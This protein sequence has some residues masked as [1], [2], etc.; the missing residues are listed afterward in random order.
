[1]IQGL[2]IR[3]RFQ[4]SWLRFMDVWSRPPVLSETCVKLQRDDPQCNWQIRNYKVMGASKEYGK[5]M[6]SAYIRITQIGC[7]YIPY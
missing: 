4:A 2:A 6:Y 5:V 7:S 1:M 3:V